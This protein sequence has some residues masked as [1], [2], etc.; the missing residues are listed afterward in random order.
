MRQMACRRTDL[1]VIYPLDNFQCMQSLLCVPF[2]RVLDSTCSCRVCASCMCQEASLHASSIPCRILLHPSYVP[3]SRGGAVTYCRQSMRMSCLD[4]WVVPGRG[5]LWTES[6]SLCRVW[7]HP[8][9]MSRCH[10]GCQHGLQSELRFTTL[11]V[12]TSRLHESKVGVF[13]NAHFFSQGQQVSITAF[14]M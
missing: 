14:S 3:I 13:A 4:C 11:C 7:N 2:H 6:R 1:A 9:R 5:P 8:T 12:R 10:G